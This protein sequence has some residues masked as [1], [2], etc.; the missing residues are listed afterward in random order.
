MH[1]LR[2][3][4]LGAGLKLPSLS[5]IHERSLSP[6]KLGDESNSRRKNC[7]CMSMNPEVAPVYGMNPVSFSRNGYGG[8]SAWP[9][10]CC[11]LLRSVV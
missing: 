11:P 10:V 7:G 8:N 5:D 1:S 4:P 9:F 6:G 3:H 2:L